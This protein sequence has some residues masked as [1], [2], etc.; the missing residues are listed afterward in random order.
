MTETST[1]GLIDI[2]QLKVVS[3]SSGWSFLAV[4]LVVLILLAIIYFITH[5]RKNPLRHLRRR[6]LTQQLSV[7]QA[8]H[9][10][11]HLVSLDKQQTA[12]L[13][14]IRFARVE[15]TSQQLLAFML[16]IKSQ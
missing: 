14:E 1:A 2:M 5:Y 4:A 15:P 11:S 9:Q 12:Q 3:N 13:E 10:L 16:Q 7:R 6:L 8:A